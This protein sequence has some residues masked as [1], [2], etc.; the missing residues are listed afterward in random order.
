MLIKVATRNGHLIQILGLPSG[1]HRYW[2]TIGHQVLCHRKKPYVRKFDTADSAWT[3]AL[4]E[5]E[6]R[7]LGHAHAHKT[8]PGYS[9]P[10][11]GGPFSPMNMPR[12]LS[13][14]GDP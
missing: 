1:R 9:N 12:P 6:R 4:K 7:P 13:K 2:V 8:V 11:G 3:A 5:A 10:G 14:R